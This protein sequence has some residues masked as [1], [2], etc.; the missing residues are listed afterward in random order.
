[1]SVGSL[2]R[3]KKVIKSF[4]LSELSEMFEE[5]I[6]MTDSEDIREFYA[7]KLDEKGL[8]GLIRAGK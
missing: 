4:A 6:L 5:A 2:L 1:M 3:A 7:D 8:G